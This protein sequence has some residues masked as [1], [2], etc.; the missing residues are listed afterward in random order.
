MGIKDLF[1]N[2][3]K[4]KKELRQEIETKQREVLLISEQLSNQIKL[5]NEE[6]SKQRS[7]LENFN[8]ISSDQNKEK[9][10]L[11]AEINNL[12]QWNDTKADQLLNLEKQVLDKQ[13]E[14]K[15]LLSNQSILH[16]SL[17]SIKF[18]LIAEKKLSHDLHSEL[19]DLKELTAKNESE[20]F[21]IAAEKRRLAAREAT[22]YKNFAEMQRRE[23]V[24]AEKVEKFNLAKESV[25]VSKTSTIKSYEAEIVVTCSLP[26]VPK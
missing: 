14:I 4:S 20:N 11:V 18:E 24:L 16:D 3:P 12:K 23:Q 6:L 15:I 22:V 17:E 21:D 26:A 8:S 5:L 7:E 2:D 13:Q 19:H 25:D 9:N 10:L 1:D